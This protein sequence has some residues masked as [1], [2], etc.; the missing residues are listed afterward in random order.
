MLGTKRRSLGLRNRT[1]F[2]HVFGTCRTHCQGTLYDALPV[3]SRRTHIQL[4][5]PKPFEART[6]C[7][8]HLAGTGDHGF[9]RRMRLGAPLLEQVYFLEQALPYN[10]FCLC[11]CH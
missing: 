7:V 8:I 3:E 9:E 4:L 2:Q 5:V 11:L 1:T 6:A 10:G